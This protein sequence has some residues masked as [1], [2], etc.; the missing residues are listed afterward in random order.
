MC[1]GG[2]KV[3]KGK[4]GVEEEVMLVDRGGALVPGYDK[5]GGRSSTVAPTAESSTRWKKSC[6]K[7]YS[8][9]MKWVS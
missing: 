5:R 6:L 2:K 8:R 9:Y 4:T 1:E 3:R 7:I